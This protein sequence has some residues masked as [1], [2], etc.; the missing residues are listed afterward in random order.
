MP[1]QPAAPAE[2][3]SSLDV[4]RGAALFGVL[5]VNLL[6][7]FRVSLFAHI[8][9]LPDV[10][11]GLNSV[12]DTLTSGLLEFKAL[13]LFSFLFG[14][15]AAIQAERAAKRGIHTTRFLL[16][17]FLVLMAIG[18]FHVLLIWNGDILVLYAVCGLLLVPLLRLPG[19]VLVAIG[20]ALLLLPNFVSLG[21][22]WPSAEAM[23][24]NAADATRI[25]GQGSWIEILK[26]R[27]PE[28]RVFILPVLVSTLQRTLALMLLGVAAWRSGI[29]R[30]PDRHRRLLRGIL[31][32][33]ALVGGS[34]TA[35]HLLA[36]VRIPFGL[37]DAGTNIAL[38]FAYGAGMLLPKGSLRLL[39]AMGQMALTNYLVESMVLGWLFYGYG[40]GLIGKLGSA[41]AAAIGIGIYLAQ[42]AFSAIWLKHFR[43]GPFEWVWRSRTYGR[44]QPMAR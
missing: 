26:F 25:Y 3:Y 42:G 4:M 38:A 1:W 9:R 15:G 22:P 16:R 14:A 6:T 20:A 8:L 30:T 27:V 36:K 13:T 17:R 12:V 43:F 24:A 32:A 7:G 37:E 39:A 5:M 19:K 21:I 41:P 33:C 34:L 11:G 23:R 10:P 31:L 44:L 29:L 2:R 35:L 18:L 40:L 28:A